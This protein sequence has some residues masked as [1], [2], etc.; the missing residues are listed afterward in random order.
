L[1][2]LIK[3][4]NRLVTLEQATKPLISIISDIHIKAAK[5]KKRASHHTD[6]L[7][8]DESATIALYTMEW[9]PYAKLRTENRE[10]LKS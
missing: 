6:D 7:S 9:H 4:K 3:K 5:A 10:H 1:K 8:I 2:D